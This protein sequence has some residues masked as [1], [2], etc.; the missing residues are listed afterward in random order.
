MK[1]RRGWKCGGGRRP[2][3]PLLGPLLLAAAVAV[4]AA[5]VAASAAAAPPAPPSSAPIYDVALDAN[6][7]HHVF[8]RVD[9]AAQRLDFEVHTRGRALQPWL[10]LGFSDRGLLEGADMCALWVDW[11]GRV[12][13]QNALVDSSGRFVVSAHQDC[14]HFRHKQQD[15][16]I[17]FTFTRK[18]DTCHPGHYVITSGTTHLVWSWGA[19]PLYRLGGVLAQGD[20]TGMLRV[21][22]LKPSLP[23]TAP[24]RQERVLEV[25]S[26][27]VEVPSEETTYWCTVE[28]LPDTFSTKHHIVE[29]GPTIQR[30][31]EDIVHHM[32]VF[33]C[34]HPPDFQ[35]PLYQGPCHS[36][37]RPREIDA[38]KRVLAAWAMGASAFVYPQEAGLP[39]GGPDF[40][41][42]LM[43][44][45]HYNN[46]G[47]LAGRVDSSGIQL[48]Y[49]P[50]PRPY[51][52]GI[53]ELGLE[54]TAKMAIP[55]AMPSFTLAGYC[56]PECTALGLP[57][58][59]IHIFGSQLHT[60]LT[61]VRAWTKHLRGS[62][63]LPE[64]NR[65]DHY[66]THFQ[67]IRRL[68]EAV[69][70][71][72]GDALVMACEYTTKDRANA[73]LG[74][75]SISDEMCV[76]Y[77]HY[78]PKV[79]LEVCKSSVDSATLF[80]Y[81]DFLRRW[82]LQPTSR[83]KSWRENYEAVEWTP[84]RAGVLA[85]L[86]DHAPLSM[87]C[88]KSSGARFPGFWENMSIPRALHPLP[89][90]QRKCD[91]KSDAMEENQS[92]DSGETLLN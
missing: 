43:L 83:E 1:S 85:D 13:F 87:Q 48:H 81:F 79:D 30:G 25:R 45:V 7:S 29:F 76:N 78:F 4:A 75:F 57:P 32:E 10:A 68:P 35:V 71:L 92:Q 63:E 46:P 69:H 49:T 3:A 40:N 72:P 62:E 28:K 6:N 54:Y 26:K 14:L 55:P 89:E 15:G 20:Q 91:L 80:D 65:D 21:Q 82:E 58:E 56:I 86:Y 39:M 84:L 12:R 22:L 67:E 42:F 24:R 5:S 9:R 34:E 90:P 11:R 44:E 2:C 51:D 70:V 19:G 52:A 37:D 64:L 73:T 77:V 38:C 50:R 41:P 27:K 53:M 33:H 60:H 66:S 31:N 36:P 59:G 88:N 16:V 74:G 23:R 61:G 17:K 8:W 47:L 18:L